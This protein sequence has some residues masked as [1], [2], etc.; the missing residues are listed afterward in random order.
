M[1]SLDTAVIYQ[2]LVTLIKANVTFFYSPSSL[3]NLGDSSALP[4][5][6]VAAISTVVV[7]ITL[8]VMLVIVTLVMAV[9]IKKTKNKMPA[10]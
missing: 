9:I 10:R 2:L 3:H 8:I 6:A 5:G 4:G 7:I 1:P